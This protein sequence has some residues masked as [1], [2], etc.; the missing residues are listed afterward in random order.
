MKFLSPWKRLTTASSLNLRLTLTSGQVF[1]WTEDSEG[2]WRGVIGSDCI[3]LKYTDDV[4]EEKE[5]YEQH[6]FFAHYPPDSE[7]VEAKL[8]DFFQL[9]TNM[10]VLYRDWM[11]AD[12]TGN[13]VNVVKDST[14]HGLRICR[15]D[16]FECLCAFIISQNNHVKRISSILTTIRINYGEKLLDLPDGSS[17]YAWPSLS[18]LADVSEDT[19]RELGLGYRAKYYKL[20]T[21]QLSAMGG[22]NSLHDLRCDDIFKARETL[23]SFTGVGRKVAD[24]V[25]LFS[26]DFK[27]LVPCDTHV[28]E[29]SKKYF[30]KP[31]KNH[32][33][34]QEKFRAIFGE[35]AG[36]AH[37]V[38][39]A[40]SLNKR[41]RAD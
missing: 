19:W 30:N 3:F 31:E 21:N 16:P 15:Q 2:I 17:L 36:W 32:D 34:I 8:R 24:C 12:E 18:T 9:E 10:S 23:T 25:S 29:I 1:T 28:L 4:K 7:G 13:F 33:K 20:T 38:L 35:F 14:Y 41:K 6:V 40:A 11:S 27:W 39:F 26:L 37:C 5:N 22:S